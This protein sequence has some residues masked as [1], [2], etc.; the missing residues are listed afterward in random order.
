MHS[1]EF[2]LVQY[3][4]KPC[5]SLGNRDFYQLTTDKKNNSENTKIDGFWKSFR[6]LYN[7]KNKSSREKKFVDLFVIILIIY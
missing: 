2:Y 7:K 3:L 5:I 4:S 6:K 1:S